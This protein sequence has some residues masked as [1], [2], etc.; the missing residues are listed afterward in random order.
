MHGRKQ[1]TLQGTAESLGSTRDGGKKSAGTGSRTQH[2]FVK[3]WAEYSDFLKMHHSSLALLVHRA[4]LQ[5]VVV[6]NHW[7]KNEMF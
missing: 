2:G 4:S 1:E 7:Q 3:A 5:T 6:L